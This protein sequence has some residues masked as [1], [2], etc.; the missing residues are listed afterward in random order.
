[1]KNCEIFCGV[2]CPCSTTCPFANDCKQTHM[3]TTPFLKE[4]CCLHSMLFE[5][6][7]EVQ[8]NQTQLPLYTINET[9][10][11]A[12][13]LFRGAIEKL[14]KACYDMNDCNTNFATFD[15]CVTAWENTIRNT[16]ANF[17]RE[18]FMPLRSQIRLHDLSQTATTEQNRFE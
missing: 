4:L 12:L 11:N 18:A 16:K 8:E 3:E 6:A 7:K 14:C 17:L 1:M 15:K 2:D 5:M 9:F 10:F 13:W